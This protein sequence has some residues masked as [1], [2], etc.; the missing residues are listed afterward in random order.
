MI[1]KI[2]RPLGGEMSELLIYDKE[3]TF[4]YSLPVAS[5]D[6]K[7]LLK[8]IGKRPKMYCTAAIDKKGILHIEP[9]DVQGQEW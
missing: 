7:F 6:G 5:K 4:E 9:D 8:R 3:H 1:V 2:Q